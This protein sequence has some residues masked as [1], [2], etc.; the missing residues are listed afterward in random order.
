[1]CYNQKVISKSQLV[2]VT[3]ENDIWKISLDN[4][5]DKDKK[6]QYVQLS[7]STISKI[8]II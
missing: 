1:M 4:S 6:Y 2:T 8:L 3:K 5:N 7:N